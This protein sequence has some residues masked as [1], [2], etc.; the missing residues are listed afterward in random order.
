[1]Y[2]DSPSLKGY[3]LKKSSCVKKKIMK[4]SI[5]RTITIIA[6]LMGFLSLSAP[7][8]IIITDSDL[9]QHRS[10]EQGAPPFIPE[11][12]VTYDQ[13]APLSPGVLLLSGLGGLYLLKKCKKRR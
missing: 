8:Q 9:N 7:A 5:K 12:G 3:G 10:M 13:Y 4:N 1:M 6:F 11:L 2:C